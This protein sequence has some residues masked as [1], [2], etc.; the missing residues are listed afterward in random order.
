MGL[1]VTPN[2]Y[3]YYP[4]NWARYV[5]IKPSDLELHK[6]GVT[7]KGDDVSR[8]ASRFR[9]ANS[10]EGVQLST[11][12]SDDTHELL[13]AGFRVFLTYSAFEQYFFRVAKIKDN[14]DID[15]KNLQDA[16]DQSDVISRIRKHDPKY[17]F[18]RFTQEELDKPHATRMKDFIAGKHQNVSFLGKAIRHLFTHGKLAPSSGGVDVAVKPAIFKEIHDFLISAMDKDFQSRVI[19]NLPKR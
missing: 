16:Y 3:K 14:E 9:I 11:I 6:I 8:W 5:T 13:D 1:K 19:A 12:M 4:S 17:V 2:Y 15:L 7:E 18:F 10:F